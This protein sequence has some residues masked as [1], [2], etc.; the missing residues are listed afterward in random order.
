M[1][2]TVLCVDLPGRRGRPARAGSVSIAAAAAAVVGDVDAAGLDE[3]V[4]VGHSLAGVTL[5]AVIGLLGDRVRHAV[6]I[7]AAVPE[8]GHAALELAPADLGEDL[9]VGEDLM[10]V[11]LGPELDDEQYAWCLERSV[12][13][14]PGLL[15]EPVDLGPLAGALPPRTWVRTLHDALASPEAQLR[16]ARNAGAAEV[17]DLD[18]GHMCMVSRPAELAQILNGI[19]ARHQPSA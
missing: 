12:E 14:P 8:H 17:V 18:A 6:F 13:E 10:R 7:A 5:P 19:I 1:R 2:G 3:V 11:I 9:A 4:L 16:S 15:L